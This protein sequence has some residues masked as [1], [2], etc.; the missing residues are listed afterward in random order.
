[1]FLKW[2]P[3]YSVNIKEFDE[4]HQKIFSIINQVYKMTN[5]NLNKKKMK[6][7]VKELQDYGNYHLKAEEKYF[8]EFN[9]PKKDVHIA[10]H[11]SYR[12]KIEIFL[13][14]CK[15]GNNLDPVKEMSD[16]LKNW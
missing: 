14:K 8:E 13:D 15:T 7:I 5:K 4:Q 16:F 11:N 1:M 9:Y 12:K 6:E 2:D 3:I 10:A